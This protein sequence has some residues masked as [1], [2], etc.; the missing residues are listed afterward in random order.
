MNRT[1]PFSIG[2][3][4]LLAFAACGGGGSA[5]APY[6][7]PLT[8]PYDGPG[9][10]LDD[11]T[12][13][14]GGGLAW[15]VL[16]T[17][18]QST[19]TFLTTAVARNNTEYAQIYSLYYVPVPPGIGAPDIGPPPVDFS[20]EIVV[21]VFLGSRPTGGYSVRI[22]DIVREG[23]GI[24]VTAEETQPGPNCVVS[25]AFTQPFVLVAVTKVPGAV[26]FDHTT[27]IQDCP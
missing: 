17:G 21:A 22:A 11:G 13:S 2:L 3:L 14:G 4:A 20:S 7:G 6:D 19:P 23:D 25:Q 16:A 18:I 5:P 27:V 1:I 24:R 9:G 8:V 26:S 12:G 15:R 10:G